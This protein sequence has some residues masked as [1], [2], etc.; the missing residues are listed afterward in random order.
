M[1]SLSPG[2]TNVNELARLNLKACIFDCLDQ[3]GR[4]RQIKDPL[5]PQAVVYLADELIFG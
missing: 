1:T 3:F 5:L 4:F 2:A